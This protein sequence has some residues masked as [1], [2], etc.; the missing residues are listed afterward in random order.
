MVSGK[1]IRDQSGSFLRLGRVDH[2]SPTPVLKLRLVNLEHL[3]F[4]QL[5]IRYR[6]GSLES[7]PAQQPKGGMFLA[8]LDQAG[9]I[10]SPDDSF[11]FKDEL[12]KEWTTK[13][14]VREITGDA[15]EISID[16]PM[17]SP[18]GAFDISKLSIIALQERPW[19]PWATGALIVL[20]LAWLFAIIS[21]FES[22]KILRKSAASIIILVVT[23]ITIFPQTHITLTSF[24]KEF[25]TDA[26]LVEVS[27]KDI[28]PLEPEKPAG[29]IRAIAKAPPKKHTSAKAA[30]QTAPSPPA[31]KPK[32]TAK[33]KEP[34]EIKIPA[35]NSGKFH[36]YFRAFLGSSGWL[37]I[38][39]FF[40]FTFLVLIICRS[41][42]AWRI[43]LVLAALA[44]LVPPYLHYGFEGSDFFDFLFNLAGIGLAWLL[45][46][47]LSSRFPFLRIEEKPTSTA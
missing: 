3:R 2:K 46:N 4:F 35:K 25:K 31:L 28:V 17:Y 5:S 19:I 38:P 23:W 11:I 9:V 6:G 40:A 24:G 44:E 15:H 1:L 18:E 37:H 30:T 32:E 26:H 41:E 45:A 33:Q 47:K 16:L 14:V 36:E 34:K 27:N 22:L 21:T 29:T 20:W 42:A 12:P 13:N 10:S 8:H 7:K 39:A 43:A